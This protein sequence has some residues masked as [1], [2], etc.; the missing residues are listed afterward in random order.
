MKNQQRNPSP[1]AVMGWGSGRAGA[2]MSM[3][4]KMAREA[5]L[6]LGNSPESW[7]IFI[8]LID[9]LLDLLL[10]PTEEMEEAGDCE[11]LKHD[12]PAVHSAD[13]LR[14]MIRAA[15]EGK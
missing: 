8:F 9:R 15:L 10:T 11:L 1:V 6:L 3:R 14:A 4:E 7:R 2:T 5:A 12:F 13:A